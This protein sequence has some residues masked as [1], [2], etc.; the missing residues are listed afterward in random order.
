M[1]RSEEM[2]CNIRHFFVPENKAC[3]HKQHG[4]K[5]DKEQWREFRVPDTAKKKKK[6]QHN[7]VKIVKQET[8]IKG[9]K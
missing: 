7:A 5:T 6:K 9:T 4:R 3:I 2:F 8:E 1:S